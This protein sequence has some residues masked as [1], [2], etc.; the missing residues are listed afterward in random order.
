M[1]LL[2]QLHILLLL[3]KV[4]VLIV[5]IQLFSKMSR[6]AL[7]LTQPPIYWV[8]GALSTG[9]KWSPPTANIKNEWTYMSTP[10]HVFMAYTGKTLHF[11]CNLQV[12]NVMHSKQPAVSTIPLLPWRKKQQ[13]A[14]ECCCIPTRLHGVT[15]QKTIT[16][17]FITISTILHFNTNN[18]TEHIH[19]SHNLQT[20]VTKKLYI[21]Y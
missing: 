12:C 17:T 1:N 10:P 4:E 13:G 16:L 18:T 8:A 9:I 6:L 15:S 19:T 5:V 7:G 20:G 2:T 14:L 11:L 3:M 21:T